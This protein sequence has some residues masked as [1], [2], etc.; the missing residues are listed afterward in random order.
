MRL[1]QWNIKTPH[2]EE[3]ARLVD[4]LGVHRETAAVLYGRGYTD[5]T[6]A[7]AFLHKET[8][9]FYDPFLLTDMYIAA[10][11]V[12]EALEHDERITIYGDYDVDGV[13]AT[14]VL[15]LYLRS[16]GADVHTFIP[17]RFSEGYGLNGEAVRRIAEDGTTLLITVDTGITATE[18][19]ELCRTL[20]ISLVITDHHTCRETLPDAVAIVNPKRPDDTYPFKELAGVGVA[21]KLVCAIACLDCKDDAVRCREILKPIYMRYAEYTAI[22]T[23]ADVMPLRDE[24]RLIVYLG[25]ALMENTRHVGL[26]ALIEA[27][28]ASEGEKTGTPQ[29]K[30]TRRMTAGFLSFGLAPRINAV[31]RL[32]GAERAVELFCTESPTLAATIAE[33][34]CEANRERQA[35]E[36]KI[37]EEAFAQVETEHDLT[38]ECILVLSGEH[39]HHG[40]IGIVASRVTER[41]HMPCMLISFDGNKEEPSGDD[42][43]RGSG[44]SIAGFSLIDAI[45]KSGDMLTKY[46]GHAGAA[47]L[48][49]RRDML[50][51]FR[52]ALQ[53]EAEAVFDGMVPPATVEIDHVMYPE[54]ATVAL[55][56]EL[57]LLEPYGV[58]NP[59][60][61]FASEGLIISQIVPLSGGKHTKFVLSDENNRQIVR[62]A[63]WFGVHTEEIPFHVGDKV[64]VAYQLGVNDFRGT[65]SVQM[66]LQDMRFYDAKTS[67]YWRHVAYFGNIMRGKAVSSETALHPADMIPTR[68]VCAWV[69]TYLRRATE[70][71]KA[72]YAS[73]LMPLCYHTHLDICR[74]LFIL[75]IFVDADLIDYTTVVQPNNV[76][77]T[78]RIVL[79]TE[80]T[81]VGGTAHK[82]K[83]NL[84][85][86]E[87]AKHLVA[88][89]ST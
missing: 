77:P 53:N 79:H 64:D 59:T 21:F 61:V 69:Y 30:R 43:G 81:A 33:E 25:L 19:A 65:K 27:A 74:V 78:Y 18:E 70:N 12:K 56:E 66:L 26:R 89:F 46:G 37:A 38:N 44:R 76:V 57:S 87:T 88:L 39:W 47:G 86:T 4:M 16:L 45:S 1:K 42:I 15:F 14:S 85:E 49:I 32:A 28:S 60:P 20:G 8:G 29:E 31:G 62:D 63:L 5:P 72:P 24:N 48:S 84:Y 67:F 17:G 40:V 36:N 11:R 34:L 58:G 41:Y 6:T 82:E 10:T 71:G 80:N 54:D 55:C 3:I 13:T 73:D 22:G 68:E 9:Q 35:L 23:V 75:E 2:D 52:D 50:P 7:K 51:A 83:K